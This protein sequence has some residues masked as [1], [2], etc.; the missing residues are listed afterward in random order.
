MN[1][2]LSGTQL[3][4]KL[5]IDQILSE[6]PRLTREAIHAAISFAAEALRA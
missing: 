3:Y 2:I 4:R 5:P 6:H 1:D